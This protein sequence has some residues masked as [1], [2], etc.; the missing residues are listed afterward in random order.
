MQTCS[1]IEQFCRVV[2]LYTNIFLFS[3]LDWSISRWWYMDQCQDDT[4]KYIP[5]ENMANQYIRYL[6]D[7][8]ACDR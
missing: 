1:M 5:L 2:V 8:Q 7:N 6:D 4:K 3:C